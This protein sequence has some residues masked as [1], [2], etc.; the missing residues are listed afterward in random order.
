MIHYFCSQSIY[1]DI[2][3]LTEGSLT[4]GCPLG[5]VCQGNSSCCMFESIVA[6][7]KITNMLFRI[8]SKK[9]KRIDLRF[10]D[11]FNLISVSLIR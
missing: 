4:L 3:G 9:Y 11:I 1:A 2:L 7:V 10:Y 8:L 6:I 5:Y